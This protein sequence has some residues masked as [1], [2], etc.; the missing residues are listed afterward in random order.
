MNETL[1]WDDLRA[2]WL[3]AQRGGITSAARQ[4]GSSAPTLSRQIRALEAIIGRPL[5]ERSVQGMRLAPAG[6]ELL[7][8]V[9]RMVGHADRIENWRCHQNP[10]R[11]IRIAAG[12]F[13][14]LF[15]ARHTPFLTT[16][17]I[18]LKIHL[19]SSVAVH[20]ISRGAADISLRN[21]APSTQGLISR[22]LVKVG[23]AVY[24]S[25]AYQNTQSEQ[26][27][28]EDRRISWVGMAGT[29]PLPPSALWLEERLGGGPDFGCGSSAELLELVRAGCGQAVLPCFIGDGDKDLVRIGG[30]IDELSHYQQLVSR[31]ESRADPAIR[32]V[33]RQLVKLFDSHR[34]LFS[35]NH[36]NPQ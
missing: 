6:Q 14:S 24:A 7:P 12:G 35:G 11:L 30:V 15:L 19:T 21:R 10:T 4:A 31:G 13:T 5:F 33:K 3:V 9:E 20:P 23:F 18:A 34:K 8:M 29:T 28:R 36:S 32:Q 27:L 1:D 25:T 22:A 17:P 26:R 16:G 2:F